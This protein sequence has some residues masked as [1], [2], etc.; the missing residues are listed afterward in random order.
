MQRAMD[1]TVDG[2][3][4][5][6]KAKGGKYVRD[7]FFAKDP[8]LLQMAA[9]LSDDDIYRLNRGGHDPYKIYAAYH[10]ATNHTGQPTVS[11]KTKGYG[12]GDA[13]ESENTT[14]QVKKLDLEELEDF[15]DRFDVPLSD[16]QLQDVPYSPDL[17]RTA[18][19]CR[20]ETKSRAAGR[21][22]AQKAG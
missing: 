13:G 2:E 17:Q 19:K 15:R 11:A 21:F 14:H 10:A 6:F 1:A 8:E 7:N 12:M 20:F 3:Y 5:N 4:Q 22:Y 16:E 9:H 18:L